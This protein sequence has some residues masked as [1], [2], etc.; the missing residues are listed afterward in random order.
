MSSMYKYIIWIWISLNSLNLIWPV[1]ND[2]Q[3]NPQT[4][5]RLISEFNSVAQGQEFYLGFHMKLKPGWHS[6]WSNPGDAGFA[7]Q[8]DYSLSQGVES[9]ELLYPVPHR[10]EL[11]GGLLAF[12]YEN[13]V[14]YPIRVK[15]SPNAEKV[16]IHFK[17]HFLVCE[18]TCVPYQVEHVLDLPLT[19]AAEVDVENQKL[20][21]YWLEQLPLDWQ[22]QVKI[23][24]ENV[25]IVGGQSIFQL[26][27]KA[28]PGRVFQDI[29]IFFN[30]HSE[31]SFEKPEIILLDDQQV[32]IQVPVQ[33]ADSKTNR[34]TRPI[35]YV[36]K[37][38][39]LNK[40]EKS[41][42]RV[43]DPASPV[44]LGNVAL[45]HPSKTL[46]WFLM[47]MFGLLGGF[48]LNFMPCVLPVLSIKLFGF[49]KDLKSDPY[50]VRVG[51]WMTVL[52]ILISFGFLAGGLMV[53]KLGGAVVGWGIQFQ[54]PV[55]ITF[56]VLVV[57]VFAM[58][59]FGFFE[60]QLPSRFNVAIANAAQGTGHSSLLSHFIYGL[61]ATLLATPCSAP[62]LGTAIGFAFLQSNLGLLLI[63]LS[64]G[65]GLAFPYILL[66]LNP[67]VLRFFPKPGDWMNQLRI[68]LGFVLLAS[69]IWLLF[70][71]ANQVDSVGLAFIELILIG[72]GFL[73]WLKH[74]TYGKPRWQ[75]SILILLLFFSAGTIYLAHTSRSSDA[76][77]D[78]KLQHSGDEIPWEVFSEEKLN[79]YLK[80]GYFVFVDVTADWCFTCKFNEKLVLKNKSIV[81]LFR[82]K[83]IKALKADWTRKDPMIGQYLASFQKRGIPFYVLYK[84]GQA[85]E[86]FSEILTV[87]LIQEKFST[88]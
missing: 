10:Y 8:V 65:S 6:Y 53:A 54:E 82:D 16:K 55:F 48:L 44:S 49:L 69:L 50:Q 22:S 18:K 62:F 73:F 12:G 11:G 70:V 41:F 34:I 61:F 76:G 29:D 36:V 27:V 60:I 56:L 21:Q 31:I 32:Q 20:M 14:V 5:H 67:Q 38:L 26:H 1:E 83:H 52:G 88:L 68:I 13:E 15:I 77:T 66:A 64:I 79:A 59:L 81:E 9:V 43:F 23:L 40:Q 24:E 35:S 45:E 17:I 71:L 72:L 74:L 78:V 28:E 30:T 57:F 3:V 51:A 58:N 25:D 37:G 75:N 87:G 33:Y 80:E 39:W 63:F 42:Q 7:P 86:V 47:L 19:Q 84:K 4:E 85:P 46:N 2:W